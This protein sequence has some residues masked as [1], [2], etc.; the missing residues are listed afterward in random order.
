MKSSLDKTS[1]FCCSSPWTLVSPTA[2]LSLAIPARRTAALMAFT[3]DWM[4]ANNWDKFPDAVG[5]FLCSAKT[6]R[7]NVMQLVSMGW[8]DIFCKIEYTIYN[9]YV[10][11]TISNNHCSIKYLFTFKIDWITDS[12]TNS[13]VMIFMRLTNDCQI[14]CWKISRYILGAT[15]S[16]RILTE[17]RY[18]LKEICRL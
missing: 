11:T 15:Y 14:M 2:P 12:D 4:L 10:C 13:D 6:N 8:P 17:I 5:Y 1:N 3:A 18:R 9:F 7:V 16:K